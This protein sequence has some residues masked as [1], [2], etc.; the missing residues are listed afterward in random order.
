MSNIFKGALLDGQIYVEIL[1]CHRILTVG[2]LT[3]YLVNKIQFR[4]NLYFDL[5]DLENFRFG[6]Q[7]LQQP[8]PPSFTTNIVSYIIQKFLQ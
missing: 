1:L 6:S 7:K 8:P 4:L 5:F 2:S 3:V